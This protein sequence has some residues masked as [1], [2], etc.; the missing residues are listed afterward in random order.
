MPRNILVAPSILSADPGRYAEEIRSIE[1]CGARWLHID[2]MDGSFVPPITFGANIVSVARK[3]CSL[4][5]DTHLMIVNPEKHIETFRKAGADLIT[6]HLEACSR[7][8]DVLEIIR[9]SG[10][11][12]GIS[13]SP[14]SDPVRLIPL[15][16]HCDLVLIMT[17]NPGW[18]GQK[19]MPEC[20]SKVELLSKEAARRKLAVHIEVD[21]GINHETGLQCVRAGA[22]VLVAGNYIFTA[23]DRRAVI[24]RLGNLASAL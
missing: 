19:F 10:A 22:D 2:V 4:F 15:L 20:L 9:A 21:G 13:I 5:L 1:E 17:V 14:P 12:S 11:K 7:P 6:V 24:E 18:G 8:A 3:Q 16:E 23:P